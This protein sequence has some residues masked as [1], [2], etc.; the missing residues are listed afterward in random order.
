MITLMHTKEQV[1]W[2]VRRTEAEC[3]RAFAETEAKVQER[4]RKR[5]GEERVATEKETGGDGKPFPKWGEA[6]GASRSNVQEGVYTQLLR[7][8]CARTT[9][10]RRP[11]RWEAIGPKINAEVQQKGV[12]CDIKRPQEI[13]HWPATM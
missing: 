7:G 3:Q 4:S 11:L 8:C 2:T 1:R 10:G 12:F 6:A 9:I 13:L 5:E